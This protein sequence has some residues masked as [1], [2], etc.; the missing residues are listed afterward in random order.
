MEEN[1]TQI[2]MEVSLRMEGRALILQSGGK[3][4]FH[5][6]ISALPPSEMQTVQLIEKLMNSLVEGEGATLNLRNTFSPLPTHNQQDFERMTQ[7]T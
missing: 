1:F 5:A 2:F 4:L 3:E 7:T 6:L